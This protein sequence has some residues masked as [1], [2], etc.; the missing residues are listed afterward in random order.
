MKAEEDH[1]HQIL[2]REEVPIDLEA[3]VTHLEKLLL[4]NLRANEKNVK[5]VAR[6][7][8]ETGEED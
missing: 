3:R 4:L 8:P 2:D 5:R 6:R 1:H 7:K